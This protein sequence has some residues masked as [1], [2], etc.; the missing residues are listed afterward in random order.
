M[1]AFVGRGQVLD[2]RP[3]PAVRLSSGSAGSA[4]HFSTS[5][6][7]WWRLR[8]WHLLQ[9]STMR[10]LAG[11]IPRSAAGAAPWVGWTA[12]ET[13]SCLRAAGEVARRWYGRFLVSASSS[14]L[15]GLS[16]SSSTR[17]A[18][19]GCGGADVVV[20]DDLH[21]DMACI[22]NDGSGTG[23]LNDRTWV[24]NDSSTEALV[25]EPWLGYG[26]HRIE[27]L[28]HRRCWWLQR[29]CLEVEVLERCARSW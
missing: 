25:I 17:Y 4:Y 9:I 3:L 19:G 13:R 1:L 7:S 21:M 8:A 15:S 14:W 18:I 22:L 24:R 23:S 10:R 6:T 20:S 26:S 16:S 12:F 27:R 2:K 5:G 11:R 29:R 28:E